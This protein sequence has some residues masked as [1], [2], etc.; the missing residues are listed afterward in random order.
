MQVND[1]PGAN[2][3]EGQEAAGTR[4]VPEN[5]VS[6]TPTDVNVTFPVFVTEKL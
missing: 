4:A 6:A 5:A 2:G 3:V 1:A